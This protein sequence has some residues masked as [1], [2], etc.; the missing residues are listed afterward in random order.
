M[1]NQLRILTNHVTF[2]Q[3][4]LAIGREF[5]PFLRLISL[6]FVENGQLLSKSLERLGANAMNKDSE[7]EIGSALIKF[8]IVTKELSALM[9]TL[10]SARGGREE[11]QDKHAQ[12]K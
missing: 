12:R 7:A 1:S 10:V 2:I 4:T 8:S 6:D 5:I 3:L 11:E 9:K